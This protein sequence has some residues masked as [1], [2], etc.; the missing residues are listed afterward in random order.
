MERRNGLRDGLPIVHTFLRLTRF[1]A[2]ASTPGLAVAAECK[3]KIA[4][5]GLADVLPTVVFLGGD[6]CG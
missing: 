5:T 4:G 1:L 6:E 2:Q 3:H